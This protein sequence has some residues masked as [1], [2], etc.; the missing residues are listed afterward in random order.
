MDF[1]RIGKFMD[2]IHERTDVPGASCVV[3]YKNERVYGYSTGYADRENGVKMNGGEL[4]NMYSMTKPITCTAALQLY[5]RG[6]FRLA[7]PLYYYIPEFKDMTYRKKIDG[8]E[9]ILPCKNHIMIEDLFTMSAG[10]NYNLNAPALEEVKA[11]TGGK[12]PTVEAIRALAKEPLDFEP[13]THFQY[14]LCHDVLGALIE[15]LTGEKFADYMQK[16]IFA[17]CGMKETGFYID[18]LGRERLAAQYRY[19]YDTNRSE[20]TDSGCAYKLGS[21]YESGG[22]GLISNVEDYAKFL[23]TMA[24]FGRTDN[25]EIILSKNTI[26]L[27]RTN[28]L[29]DSRETEAPQ[30]DRGYGYGLGVRT[31]IDLVRGGSNGSIGEFAWD[32]AAGSYGLID[33]DKQVA[34]CYTQHLLGSGLTPIEHVK[35]RNVM[36]SCI[37]E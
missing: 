12:T 3:Y 24:A 5:E 36:Y 30:Y 11:K 15:I 34:M 18:K 21:E 27:M 23:K 35:L 29:N 33:P 6:M 32:G 7:D 17:P 25:G 19:N 22:A 4:Y 20:R 1:S 10:L 8:K 16:N 31:M 9:E 28:F 37:Y 13:H 2:T 14:S 26:N